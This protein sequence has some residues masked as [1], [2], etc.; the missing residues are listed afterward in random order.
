[1]GL[2]ERKK[3]ETRQAIHDAAMELFGERGFDEVSVVE[4]AARAKVS[5]M[6]VFNY[7][8]TKEDIVLAPM[9]D[10]LGEIPALMSDRLPGESVAATARRQFLDALAR[11]APETGLCDR[12]EFLRLLNLMRRTPSLAAR[13]LLFHVKAEGRLATALGEDERAPYAASMIY[14]L[15]RTLQTQNTTRIYLGQSAEQAYPA[16]VGA[17][18]KGFAVLADGLGDYLA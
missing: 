3:L 13:M 5:K 11:H 8:P 14:G 10:D 15:W 12:P 7:F 2:R 18:E 6:T 1:M 9:E 16:A 17:A 4:I